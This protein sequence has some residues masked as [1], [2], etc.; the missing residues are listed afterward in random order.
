MASRT[1]PKSNVSLALGLTFASW[2]YLKSGISMTASCMVSLSATS[3]RRP[4]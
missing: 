1:C 3:M 2:E 4:V